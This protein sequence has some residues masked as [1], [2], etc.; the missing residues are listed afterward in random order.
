MWEGC[1]TGSPPHKLR[2]DQTNAECYLLPV[3]VC[4][5]SLWSTVRS[6]R[7]GVFR[8]GHIRHEL[9]GALR[10]THKGEAGIGILGG[11]RKVRVGVRIRPLFPS[12][13]LILTTITVT[14]AVD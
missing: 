14:I 12:V 4:F 9:G 5:Q 8:E 11:Q 13:F 10:V 6:L 2:I 3:L 7:I 1:K